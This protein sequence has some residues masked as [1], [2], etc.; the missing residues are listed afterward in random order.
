[1]R[2]RLIKKLIDKVYVTMQGIHGEI[3]YAK[4]LESLGKI[5]EST[6]I[7]QPFKI[8]RPSEVFIGNNVYICDGSRIDT[9]PENEK[10]KACSVRIGDN[11][12][13]GYNLSIIAGAD[14]TIG[15]NVLMASNVLI[16]SHNHGMNPES[17]GNYMHQELIRKP[18]D[19]G[20][21]CWIGQNAMI[22]PGVNIGKKCI[23]GA[24]A[25]VT[26][27]IPDYSIVGGNPARIIKS[28]N[29][30]EHKWEAV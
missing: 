3:I 16:T 30:V 10:T 2:Y 13:L 11:C 1:M 20:E 18:I 24:G 5:G 25:V 21:G 7:C 6:Y 27:S 14:V 8:A 29:F 22:M 26:K 28:Y 4:L 19:I 17:S 15:D 23:I 12:Y 9:Y